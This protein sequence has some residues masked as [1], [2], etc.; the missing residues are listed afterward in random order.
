MFLTDSENVQ[1]LPINTLNDIPPEDLLINFKEQLT[2][3]FNQL[4]IVRPVDFVSSEHIMPVNEMYVTLSSISYQ[5]ALK[6]I[7]GPQ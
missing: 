3:F 6:L 1:K 2:R 7:G 5:E 4:L